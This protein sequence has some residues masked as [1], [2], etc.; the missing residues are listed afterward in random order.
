MGGTNASEPVATTTCS[1]V[2]A[3][4][5]T[6]TTPV[7][8]RRPTP[9]SRSMPRLASQCSWFDVGVVGHHEVPPCQRGPDVHLGV[10][11]D[12]AGALDC[13][14]RPEQRLRRDAGPVGAL[15][16]DEFSFHHRHALPSRRECSR[17]VLTRC[18]AAEH[19]HVVIAHE[20]SSEPACS[21]TMN[22]A[23]QSGQSGSALPVRFSC[24]PWAASAR[25]KAARQVARRAEGGQVGFDSAGQTVGD[26]LQEPAVAVRILKCGKRVVARM[27]RITAAHSATRVVRLELRSGRTRMEHIADLGPPIDELGACGVDIGDDQVEAVGGSGFRLRDLGAE[28]ERAGRPGRRELH[29]AETIVEGEVGVE[30]PSE[31]GIERL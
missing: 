18:A 28:L 5:S 24:S 29:H 1:A 16:A 23:Y 27:V 10:C 25:R 3:T 6:S 8:A 21:A 11:T 9:R 20:G 4:P 12:I 30:P 22:A 31:T 26:L 2:W 15:A 13:F 19:D 17:T 14:A 7:P